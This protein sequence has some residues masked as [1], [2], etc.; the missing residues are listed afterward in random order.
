MA[1]LEGNDPERAALAQQKLARLRRAFHF[2]LAARADDMERASSA[3]QL[4]VLI[5][6]LVGAA[7]AYGDLALHEQASRLL[8]QLREEDTA[9]LS[10]SLVPELQGLCAQCR[11]L[12]KQA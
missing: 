11:E 2:G 3:Q 1:A 7:G 9:G 5:H 8:T 12:A 4:Y 10:A 6:R